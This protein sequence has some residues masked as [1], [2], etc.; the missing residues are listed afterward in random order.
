L[1]ARPGDPR[2]AVLLPYAEGF[3]PRQ[4]GAIALDVRDLTLTSRFRERTLIF[5]PTVDPTFEGLDF[6]ALSPVARRLL[7]RNLGLAEAF[8]RQLGRDPNFLVELHNRPNV[9]HYLGLTAP[10]LP[11]TIRLANDPFSMRQGASHRARAH[12]LARAQAVYCVSAFV[13]ARF[14]DGLDDP[15]GKVHV[16]HPGVRRTL[17]RPPEKE[18]LIL[19]VGRVVEGKGVDHLIEALLNVLPRHPEWRA[20]LV[21]ASRPGAVV[22]TPFEE[23]MGARATTLGQQ[24]R[25][26]RFLPHHEVMDHYRRAAISVVPSTVAEAF[27]RTSAEGLAHGCAMIGYASGGIPEVLGGRGIVLQERTP[28]ALAAALEQLIVDDGRRH[29]LQRRAWDDY[30][31]SVEAMVV[32]CD[33]IRGELLNRI[34]GAGPA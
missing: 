2:I 11:V 26:F 33:R 14:L 1:N 17:D 24:V 23:R 29:E 27:G 31:F 19:Y 8:R 32:R 28:A 4:A 7:G 9:F 16:V 25:W 15:E 18:R 34:A 20:E 12:I 21:G 3:G 6:H 22:L 10:R 13:R 5:G 30:P